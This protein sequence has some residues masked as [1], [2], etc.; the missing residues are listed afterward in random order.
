MV[1]LHFQLALV[2]GKLGIYSHVIYIALILITSIGGIYHVE[3]S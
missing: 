3:D 1:E 2:M